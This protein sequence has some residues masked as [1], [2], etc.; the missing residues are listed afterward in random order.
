MLGEIRDA[1]T[2]SLAVQ[3]AL[4]GHRLITT[5]HRLHPRRQHRPPAGNEPRRPYQLTS[6]LFCVVSQR[7]VR[8]KIPHRSRLPRPRPPGRNRHLLDAPLKQAILA[9]GDARHLC[10]RIYSKQPNYQSLA[11][12]GQNLVQQGI[13]DPA[14]LSRVL[15]PAD[16]APIK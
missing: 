9:R 8:K 5:L 2:A 4:S 13:T 7:L 12:A 16:S 15:G 11:Q 3:A 6:S 14:E 1:A 10:Q